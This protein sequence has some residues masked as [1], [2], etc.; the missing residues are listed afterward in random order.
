MA[1]HFDV[2]YHG[3]LGVEYGQLAILANQFTK[4]LII[5][6]FSAAGDQEIDHHSP[7]K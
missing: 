1:F 7:E 5:L 2:N 4:N 3:F 6:D